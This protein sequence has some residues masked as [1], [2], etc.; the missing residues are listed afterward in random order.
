M[1][2]IVTQTATDDHRR[3]VR[4]PYGAAARYIDGSQAV[5]QAVVKNIGRGGIAV[6]MGR[7]LRPGT[8]LTISV[9]DCRAAGQCEGLKARV[10]WSC[11]LPGSPEFHAGLRIIHDEP[12][13]VA[14][15]SRL[16]YR[17]L[18]A[19]GRVPEFAE[20]AGIDSWQVRPAEQMP[21]AAGT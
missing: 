14:E 6:T 15:V 9:S 13:A 3:F 1:Y 4:L 2:D 8:L 17:A 19:S 16:L 21:I 7:Y 10:V 20:V 11:P 18:A 12:G 5:G